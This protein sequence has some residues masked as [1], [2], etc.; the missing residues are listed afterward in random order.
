MEPRQDSFTQCFEE[1]GGEITTTISFNSK[2]RETSLF[3]IVQ[4]IVKTE[5]DGILILTNSVDA[6]LFS[7]QIIN[8]KD[9]I[10]LYGSN[11]TSMVNWFN[12]AAKAWRASHL[13]RILR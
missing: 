12:T 3:E 7:Q 11:L 2:D 4:D 5:P 8:R 10:D 6:G 13:Q 9:N 1:L